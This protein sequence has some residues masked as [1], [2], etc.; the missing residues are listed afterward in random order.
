MEAFKKKKKIL[1]KA[2]AL[3]HPNYDLLFFLF[4]HENKGVPT[5]EY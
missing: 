3:G 2:L 1:A 5:Q 4:V